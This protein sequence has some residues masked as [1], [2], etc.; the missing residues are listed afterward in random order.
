MHDDN[1]VYIYDSINGITILFIIA[2]KD[3]VFYHRCEYHRYQ[4]QLFPVF[5][6]WSIYN[7]K[8]MCYAIKSVILILVCCRLADC[9]ELQVDA[10]CWLHSNWLRTLA[11]PLAIANA[12]ITEAARVHL[13]LTLIICIA[14][15]LLPL[16]LT[17]PKQHPCASVT[18]I[19][20]AAACT[21]GV[22]AISIIDIVCINVCIVIRVV[23]CIQQTA[24]DKI[25]LAA[26]P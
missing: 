19:G 21:A 11:V 6:S 3:I 17:A 5:Y 4:G 14:G 26:A 1:F 15:L 23:V 20:M 8:N 16:H 9:L 12:A 24:A 13:R 10:C 25:A 18:I 2:N 7:D 22:C